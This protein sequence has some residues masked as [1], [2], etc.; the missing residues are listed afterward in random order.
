MRGF[1]MPACLLAAAIVSS[2]AITKPDP[3]TVERIDVAGRPLAAAPH[4][5]TTNGGIQRIVTLETP[6]LVVKRCRATQAKGT[7][8][9]FPGGGY[10]ILAIDHEG[11]AVAKLFNQAGYDA[12]VLE[13][14]IA[15][16][17]A[18]VR[19]LADA[20]AALKL[21]RENGGVL[22]LCTNRL[23]VIGFS[24][25]AHL[26]ARMMHE[27]GAAGAL[28]FAALIYPAY[29]DEQGGSEVA[30]A[31]GAK[32]AVFVLIADD[33]KAGWIDGA[34]AYTAACQAA[35]MPQEFHLLNGGGHGFGL[36]QGL[37]PPAATW[38]DL[39]KKFMGRIS[40]P[41]SGHT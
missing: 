10:Q 5:C 23:G 30:P 36:K 27:L 20:T 11:L 26:A 24:A 4:A 40:L 21:V 3:K 35:A 16:P 34:K 7:V 32:T 37:K 22:G 39:L 33:D 25:G 1:E 15:C 9:V 18:R 2:A 29:F 31:T 8:L 28:D 6:N 19:A 14:T 41:S 12:V 17:D 38:P 13:Y